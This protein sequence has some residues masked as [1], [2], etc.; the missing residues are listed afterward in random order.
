MSNN[1]KKWVVRVIIAILLLTSVVGLIFVVKY[2]AHKEIESKPVV[3]KMVVLK[4]LPKVKIP[5]AI[6]DMTID[7]NSEAVYYNDELEGSK[8]QILT[9]KSDIPKELKKEVSKADSCYIKE[10]Q[11]HY[12]EFKNSQKYIAFIYVNNDN[13]KVV[14][15]EG[16]AYKE[17]VFK[18]LYDK[19]KNKL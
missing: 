3:K 16:P 10:N 17:F 12:Y 15:A 4:T 1:V 9:V 6:K 11:F 8:I 5:E 14:T 13:I 18:L 2:R 7:L 19:I